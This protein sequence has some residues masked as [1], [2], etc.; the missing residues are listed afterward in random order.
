MRALMLVLL[1]SIAPG[2]ALAQDLTDADYVD[3]Y[4]GTQVVLITS[5]PVSDRNMSYWGELL[6]EEYMYG[7]AALVDVINAQR[8]AEGRDDLLDV[9]QYPIA[10]GGDKQ[11]EGG[12]WEYYLEFRDCTPSEAQLVL[13]AFGLGPAFASAE[14]IFRPIKVAYFSAYASEIEAIS[15]ELPG[16]VVLFDPATPVT[17]YFTDID[18]VLD[19]R[20]GANYKAEVYYSVGKSLMGPNSA[21]IS[22]TVYLDGAEAEMGYE[23]YD[24]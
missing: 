20:Y 1:L 3:Y 21:N 7:Q 4:F 23:L 2:L 9:S 22:V 6:P 16:G 17:Q 12:G 10:I 8:Q 5:A 19:A 14:V 24:Y 13:D 18:A 15:L 11:L